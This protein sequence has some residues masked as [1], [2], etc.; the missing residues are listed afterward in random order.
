MTE[1]ERR[2]DLAARAAWLAH[3]AGRTQDEIAREM[4]IS[5]QAAQR[6][7]AQ[8][9]AAG[10][11]KVR[12][13]HPLSHC[14]DLAAELQ[15]R[16]GLRLVEVAPV[17]TGLAG[18]AMLIAARIERALSQA[19]PM[20]LALGTGRTL[21]A[22][23]AQMRRIDCPQH[24][25]VSL[26]GNIAPD[27][28]AAYYNVL[29]SLSELVTARSYPLMVPVVAATAAE[30]EALHRQPGN[31]RVMEMTR[32]ADAAIIGL[33]TFG[34]SAPLLVD[35]FL[36]AAEVAARQARGAVGEILGHA[37]DIDGTFLPLD[38]RVASA[39]LP[40]TR[41][42]LVAAAA[43]GP[44]KREAILGALRGGQ[45]NGLFTDEATAT[46]LASQPSRRRR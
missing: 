25:I 36:S 14:L 7:V 27:G 19:E 13:D 26:T 46:W 40:D 29:F 10:I 38:E 24:R 32:T 43:L 33:G 44:D 2:L 35:G 1:D 9:Q 16:F 6:L 39:R 41:R 5:R 31:I 21:R 12:I 4:G 17:D 20:T 3:V 45:I 18:V 11:V 15:S 34:P 42:A 22:A 8:A 23:V 37:Y 30:R 28:S